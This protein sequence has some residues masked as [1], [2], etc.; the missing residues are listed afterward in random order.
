LL[1]IAGIALMLLA[2]GCDKQ[3]GFVAPQQGGGAQTADLPQMTITYNPGGSWFLYFMATPSYA[4]G[5]T[6]LVSIGQDNG[7]TGSTVRIWK[8]ATDDTLYAEFCMADGWYIQEAHFDVAEQPYGDDGLAHNKQGNLVPGKFKGQTKNSIPYPQCCTVAVAWT[9]PWGELAMAALCKVAQGEE[10]DGVW[11]YWNWNT[12]CGGDSPAKVLRLPSDCIW[13]TNNGGGGTYSYLDVTYSGIPGAD[14]DYNVR[15]GVHY[16]AWCADTSFGIEAGPYHV[17]LYNVF[18]TLPSWLPD[19]LTDQDAWGC[20]AWLINNRGSWVYNGTPLTMWEVQTVVW[21]LL[22]QG[23]KTPM[24]DGAQAL[25]AE[26]ILHPGYRPG[27][28]GAGNWFPVLDLPCGG[29]EDWTFQLLF[30]EVDP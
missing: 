26:A 15:N 27:V 12:G 11:T 5:Q 7:A 24:D 14:G 20:V 17:H 30:T 1:V 22:G 2:M 3:M 28:P 4:P 9:G 13:M 6:Y 23:G 16:A 19:F 8:N 10:V 25:Y 29:E 18:S 21:T